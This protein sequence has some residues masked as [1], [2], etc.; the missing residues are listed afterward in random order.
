MTANELQNIVVNLS[1]QMFVRYWLNFNHATGQTQV[2]M[3]IC[4][5]GDDNQPRDI[6]ELEDFFGFDLIHRTGHFFY[7]INRT[8]EDGTPYYSALG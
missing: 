7:V 5:R 3:A 4:C 8:K 2:Q 1:N 6:S